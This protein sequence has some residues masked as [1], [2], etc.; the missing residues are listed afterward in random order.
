MDRDHVD[1]ALRNLQASHAIDAAAQRQLR[2]EHGRI[3]VILNLLGLGHHVGKLLREL[4]NHDRPGLLNCGWFNAQLD[5]FPVYL[6]AEYE[7]GFHQR[8]DW[9]RK[10]VLTRFNQN[11]TFGRY[12]ELQEEVLARGCVDRPLALIV[13]MPA[14][15]QGLVFHSVKPSRPGM[16]WTYS[17]GK[18][19]LR[20]LYVEA[21]NEWMKHTCGQV[22]VPPDLELE[23]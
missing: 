9:S 11:K 14:F 18:G 8:A 21:A 5:W 10:N 1:R 17:Y 19:Q 22:F 23:I 7:S 20:Q 15:S 6:V 2:F 16:C 4:K 13:P 3:K 12:L